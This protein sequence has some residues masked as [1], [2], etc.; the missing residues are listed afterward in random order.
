MLELKKSKG[1]EFGNEYDSVKGPII[2]TPNT[3]Q[4]EEKIKYKPPKIATVI[5]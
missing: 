3:I 4:K 1:K 2:L 5:A